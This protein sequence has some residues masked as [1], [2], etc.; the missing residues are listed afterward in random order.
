MSRHRAR[1]YP[2]PH[3]LSDGLPAL[4]Q[5]DELTLRWLS[6]FDEVL[7]PVFVTL[8]S[9]HAYLDPTLTPEDFLEWLAG[10][11]GV[12]LDENWPV[13]RRR[14]F[15]A[16]AA[17]LYRMRGTARGLAAQVAIFTGGQVEVRDSGGVA[18][19]VRPGA[20]VPGQP[21]Y[22]VRVVVRGAPPGT[23]AA[24]LE[25]LVRAAKP[26]HV[27]HVVEMGGPGA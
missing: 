22:S 14:A 1:P 27:V 17:E 16:R 9:L 4:Y 13:E 24:R 2:S 21:G 12:L 8:D 6:A 3:P 18:W 10:W 7:A 26:A 23:D 15:V 11:V 20:R 5:E 19:S 25:A